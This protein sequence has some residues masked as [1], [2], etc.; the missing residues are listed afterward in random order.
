MSSYE[1]L[2]TDGAPVKH[3]TTGVQFEEE[4]QRQ[5]MNLAAMPLPAPV[6][7]SG[8]PFL[9]SAHNLSR[10][11]WRVYRVAIILLL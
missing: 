9:I 2:A 6:M 5:V 7:I 10:N 4:A 3:W 1:Y 8:R 11:S